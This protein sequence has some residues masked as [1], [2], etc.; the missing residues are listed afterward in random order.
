MD[1]KTKKIQKEESMQRLTDDI[2]RRQGDVRDYIEKT[3][4]TTPA[5]YPYHA[6]WE[7]W[8]LTRLSGIEDAKKV[9]LGE[10]KELESIDAAI[11]K[12][13]EREQKRIKDEAEAV[14][15]QK[16]QEKEA[17]RIAKEKQIAAELAAKKAAEEEAIRQAKIAEKE[18]EK[19][20]QIAAEKAERQARITELNNII[21]TPGTRRMDRNNK[22]S[23][24]YE[25]FEMKAISRD[26]FFTRRRNFLNPQ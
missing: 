19:L 9:L 13:E 16:E 2:V 6:G 1:L 24:L 15:K 26:E 5:G 10:H 12:E 4:V 14:K 21:D 11:I 20:A 7:K 22:I 8:L 18:A 3:L 23:A 17:K 25:L